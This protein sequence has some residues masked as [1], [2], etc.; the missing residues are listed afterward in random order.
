LEQIHPSLPF[1]KAEIIWAVR[2]EMCM[3]VEDFLSRR[4][5]ALL[6]DAEAAMESAPVVAQMMAREMQ[7][8]NNWIQTEIHSFETIAKNYLPQ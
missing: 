1:I 8:D 4:T 6:L 7:K 3:R 5:R 2:N